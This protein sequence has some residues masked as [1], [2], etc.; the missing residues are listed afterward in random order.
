VDGVD[1]TLFHCITGRARSE[2]ANRRLSTLTAN[3]RIQARVEE[4]LAESAAKAGVTEDRIVNELAKIVFSDVRNA[5]DFGMKLTEKG[6]NPTKRGSTSRR[7]RAR[8]AVHS[9]PPRWLLPA[10][11][12][13]HAPCR[14]RARSSVT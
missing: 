8:S 5:L 12:V 1:L 13:R 14:L 9:S 6:M 2:I 3:H 11:T 4:F 7:R 10:A